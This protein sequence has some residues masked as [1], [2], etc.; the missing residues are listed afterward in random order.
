MRKDVR[1][2]R[3]SILYVP[4]SNE[5]ALKKSST[6]DVDALIYDLEDSVAPNAKE[7][8][9]DS[10]IKIINSGVNKDKEQVVRINSLDTDIGRDDLKILDH[11]IPDA[12]LIPKVNSADDVIECEKL[13]NN[14]DIKIWVMMETALSIVNAYEIAKVSKALKCFVMGTNDLSTELGIEEDLKRTALKTSFEKCMMASKAYKIS[15]L[16]GVFNDIKDSEGFEQECVYSHGL[17][18]DGKTLIHPSQIN[19]CNKIF[20]PTPDQLEKARSIVSA[21]EKARKEDPEVGVI[22]FEGSQIEELHVAHARRILEAEKLIMEVSKDN[23]SIPIEVKSGS[24]YK[25]GNFFEDFSMGQKIS[26]ATPRTITLGDCSLYTALYGSRYALHSSSEFAKQLSLKESPVDD[27]LLFNI[28]FG[29]TVPDIS[30]NAIANLGYAE[31]KFLKPAYPGD[32]IT[33]HSE[34]IGLKENS[35]GD[36][37][38]VYVHSTGLNQKKEAVIDYKRW[39][40]V[41]KKNKSLPKIESVIPKLN[42]EVTKD[43]VIAISKNYQ[44]EMKNYDFT[45]AGSDLVFEDY[46]IDEKINHIDGIT[47]EEAEHMMATKLYQNNAKVHFNHFVEKGGRFGK[48]IVYGGHVIS[49]TRSISFNGLSNAFKIIAIN[50]GTHASPCFAG[51]TVFAWSKIIEKVDVSDTLGALRIRTNGLG[52][53]QPY[54]FQHQDQNG[55]FNS[56]VLLSLDY[57][58]LVP[59]KI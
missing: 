22:V 31:C 24:K 21:F 50:G 28:A 14:E 44:F 12:I 9:R 3:R 19:I 34:V 13:I 36:N 1:K 52:D 33:S 54:Q 55:K 11:C 58:A 38:V 47:V 51:K 17:G 20:T 48:R 29:K 32:T 46:K 10:I 5:K 41:R 26:H 6:L 49:L 16:D 37:G 57:W 45:A 35:N 15:I 25:I 43:E 40:M 59:K 56:D 8:A 2:P 4:G 30:L 18:F 23:E 53:A 42:S 7:G 27:F 39:V